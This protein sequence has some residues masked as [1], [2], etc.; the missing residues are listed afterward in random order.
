MQPGRR[1][2]IID[3]IKDVEELGLLRQVYGETLC[4]F[5]VFAP[6]A[7]RKQRLVN[8]GVEAGDIQKILDRDQGEVMTFGQMT[9]KTFIEADFFICNDQ[10]TDEL[11]RQILRYLEIIFDTSIHTPTKAETAMYE[12]NSKA[13]NSACMSRRVGAA[14]L[15]AGGELK[16]YAHAP[17]FLA[18][19]T[20]NRRRL[21]L[22]GRL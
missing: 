9:R 5:G 1:A 10:K 21:P 22:S 6:D 4:L 3:S 13:S 2:Y 11:Q 20:S 8:N 17:F 16:L 14:I 15:S 18:S 7:I 12:A 19:E